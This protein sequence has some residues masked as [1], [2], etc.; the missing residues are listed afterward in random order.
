MASDE[1]Q[2]KD[3]GAVKKDHPHYKYLKELDKFMAHHFPKGK[4]VDLDPG[5]KAD[6]AIRLRRVE[7]NPGI[8]L[9]GFY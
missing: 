5:R 7:K 9:K 2:L 3:G 8:T 6:K 1:V 4:K